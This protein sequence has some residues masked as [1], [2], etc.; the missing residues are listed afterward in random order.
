MGNRHRE[1]WQITSLEYLLTLIERVTRYE[2]I[3]KLSDGKAST[4]LAALNGLEKNFKGLY[5][6][7]EIEKKYNL[8]FRNINYPIFSRKNSLGREKS[9]S[10]L[11]HF[12]LNYIFFSWKYPEKPCIF[13]FL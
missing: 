13:V 3:I 11:I 4:V 2:I 8:H 10:F 9:F 6:L 12:P 7:F 5:S 1:K